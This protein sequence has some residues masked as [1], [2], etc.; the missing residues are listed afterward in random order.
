MTPAA[1]SYGPNFKPITNSESCSF[2][3]PW[4]L[5][6]RLFIFSQPFSHRVIECDGRSEVGQFESAGQLVCKHKVTRR[7][8]SPRTPFPDSFRVDHL[9]TFA[10]GGG[11]W[12]R[13]CCYSGK[14]RLMIPHQSAA[15]CPGRLKTPRAPRRDR[16]TRLLLAAATKS[17]SVLICT[18]APKGR[19]SKAQANGLG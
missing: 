4:R 5:C 13:T 3:A 8:L 12:F 7:D 19:L 18:Q 6:V 9:D 1:W 15:Q 14:P 2:F 11:W 10:R 17:G 16:S